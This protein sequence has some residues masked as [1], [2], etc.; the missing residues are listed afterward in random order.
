MTREQ[1]SALEELF[2]SGLPFPPEEREALLSGHDECVIAEV[3]GMWR[4]AEDEVFVDL[5]KGDA[6]LWTQREASQSIEE[7]R[8]FLTERDMGVLSRGQTQDR[9]H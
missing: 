8:P 2:H 1:W 7:L 5:I 9:R 3:R 4:H 6:K